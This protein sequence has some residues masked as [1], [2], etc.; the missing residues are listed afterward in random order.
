MMN[1]TVSNENRKSTIPD[2]L[3]QTRKLHV[4]DKIYVYRM[5]KKESNSCAD[6]HMKWNDISFIYF[7]ILDDGTA[8]R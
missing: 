3:K 6:N 5:K 8:E 7:S 4:S 1:K 2:V